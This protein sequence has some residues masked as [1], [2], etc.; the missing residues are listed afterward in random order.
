MLCTYIQ[1]G[2]RASASEFRYIRKVVI[3]LASGFSYA[4]MSGID[5]AAKIAEDL[6]HQVDGGQRGATPDG[7][8]HS[9]H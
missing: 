3:V 5:Y 2:I 6:Q 8:L 4:T 7:V 1:T 9:V